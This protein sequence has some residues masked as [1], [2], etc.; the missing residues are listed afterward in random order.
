MATG[1]SKSGGIKVKQEP[2]VLGMRPDGGIR[3]IKTERLT[4]FKMPRD[5]T[6]GGPGPGR[7]SRGGATKKVYTPNLNAVRN[8]NTDV[9][10]SR[11]T[12]QRK[13]VRTPRNE[14]GGKNTRNNLI[15]TMGV[16]SEGAGKSIVK[17]Y[18]EP[19]YSSGDR[20]SISSR[21]SGASKRD[22]NRPMSDA[23][24]LKEMLASSDEDEGAMDDDAMMPV[25]LQAAQTDRNVLDVAKDLVKVKVE[26]ADETSS[27]APTVST[28]VPFAPKVKSDPE[29]E[30]IPRSL[31]EIFGT[32]SS[33]LFL[34][35]LPDTLPGR[36]Q[37]IS[38]E[39]TTKD[40]D[41][42]G[43]PNSASQLNS[44]KQQDEGVIGKFVRYKSGKTKLMLG[45]SQF[46]VDVGINTDFL[47]QLVAIDA[48]PE[49]RSGNMYNLGKI[50][51]KLTA[52]PDWEHMF[53]NMI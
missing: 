13:L 41:G 9:K 17:R 11:D 29:G 36:I 37:E 38:A 44:L 14:R 10:T 18:S 42:Q 46:D 39:E 27:N 3:A 4:S 6:L 21:R 35:Q 15:Q 26:P 25:M 24:A 16:F 7:T 43:N 22:S 20:E 47:Q 19:R 30:K 8:K 2:G 51:T 23:Q 34:L 1:D 49:R 40:E 33:H 5:L 48:N 53:R 50:Q 52:T 28:T 45:N 31:E 12:Q 32:Q